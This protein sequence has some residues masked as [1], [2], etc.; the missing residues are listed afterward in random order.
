M[1][2]L[3][4]TVP[5]TEST[6]N[7]VSRKVFVGVQGGPLTELSNEIGLYTIT[8]N[9]SYNKV[10]FAKMSFRDGSMAERDF[11]LSNSDSL[12]PGNEIKVQLGYEG[13]V[14][15]VFEGIIV[16]HGI[17]VKRSGP[18]LLLIEAKDK[19]IKLT[20]ARKSAYHLNKK[21]S[22]VITHL[23][24]DL[25]KD[26]ENTTYTNKQLV[27]FNVSDWDFIVTRAEANG[28]LVFTDDGKLVVKKPST[29]GEPICTV[30]Y[31]D[32]IWEIEAETDTRNHAQRISGQSWDYTQQQLEES[33][34]STVQF[35]DTG[36]FSATEL[37]N[38]LES[39]IKLIHPGNL[40]V[41]QLN[42]WTNA[43][44][45]R[46]HLAHA[47][48]RVRIRGRA[49]IK[50]GALITLAGVGDRF[51]GN[52]FVTGILHH[53]EGQ[54]QTDVQFGWRDEWFFKKDDVMDKSAGGLLPGIS[55]L[56]IGIVKS[57]DDEDGQYR[58]KVHSPLITSESNEGVWAR[59]SAIDAGAGRG[60][61]FR[62]QENDEVVLGFLNN[63]PREPIVLGYLHSNDTKQSPLP[64]QADALQYG[65]V[66]QEG[67]KLIFD[68]TN[69]SI[70]LRIP[71]GSG[72]K[73]L[74]MDSNSGAFEMKDEHQ[75][76]IKMDAQGITIQA[77]SGKNI[78]ISGTQVAIN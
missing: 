78:T 44:A 3:A 50:P 30:T 16:K 11:E 15:T 1:A 46:T 43:Y 55:G 36:N 41:E 57:V 6:H 60:A 54:W 69:K 71:A 20:G 8:I 75:N 4:S 37:G 59:V 38:V 10:A 47:V 68:D 70:K 53:F 74:F 22:E 25:Q 73:T 76:T 28:M 39:E 58:V 65:F 34:Q 77:G 12:K 33:G 9:K 24:G 48:G 17:K 29:E 35:A 2:S 13:E 66:T 64:E 52:V 31:G 49:N 62:P 72:E 42:D 63:D 32:N 40:T 19:A 21:D 7:V 26:I 23:A 56:Q 45:M 14:E 27:Q 51:N 67:N 5:G 18:S 61:Y